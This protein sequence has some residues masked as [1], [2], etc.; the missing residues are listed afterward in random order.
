LGVYESE[1]FGSHEFQSRENYADSCAELEK[2]EI[3]CGEDFMTSNFRKRRRL[4]SGN[5]NVSIVIFITDWRCP[6]N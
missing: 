4:G 1:G 3:S 2:S 6:R 5:V